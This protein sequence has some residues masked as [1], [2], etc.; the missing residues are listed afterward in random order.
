LT[1]CE[2]AMHYSPSSSRPFKSEKY[3]AGLIFQPCPCLTS[4]STMEIVHDNP[5][6]QRFLSTYCAETKSLKVDGQEFTFFVPRDI[7]DFIDSGDPLH[8]FPLWAKVWEAA[9]VLIDYMARLQPD[10]QRR[11]LEIGAGLGVVGGVAARLGHK[12]TITEY[13]Q[14]ALEFIRAN[15]VLN[16]CRRAEVAHLDWSRPRLTSKY[17]LIIGSEVVYR[18]QDLDCLKNLFDTYLAAGGKVVLAEQIRETGKN[19][20][21]KMAPDYSIQAKKITLKSQQEPVQ[22]AVFELEPLNR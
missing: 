18:E 19:F 9:L 1:F 4:R 22:I 11:I 14:D 7:T 20:W 2:F 15:C 17:D 3:H 21:R 16:G 8:N 12:V 6:L 13:D 10:P 5:D